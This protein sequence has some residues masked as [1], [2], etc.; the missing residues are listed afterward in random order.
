[1]KCD[2]CDGTGKGGG[3]DGKPCFRCDGTGELCDVC[4]EAM[5]ACLCEEDDGRNESDD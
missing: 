4:G 5:D 1:M 2:D 3:E